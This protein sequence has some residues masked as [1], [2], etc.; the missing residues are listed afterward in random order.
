MPRRACRAGRQHNPPFPGPALSPHQHRQRRA[1]GA[2]T[3]KFPLS[4]VAARELPRQRA[5]PGR[6]VHTPFPAAEPPDRPRRRR[7][8]P[9][10][11]FVLFAEP[12]LGRR[13]AW[14]PYQRLGF[15][16][17]RTQSGSPRSPPGPRRSQGFAL[18][19][20]RRAG[21]SANPADPPRALRRRYRDAAVDRGRPSG[22][23]RG[24][25]PTA[26]LPGYSGYPA[27]PV[28]QQM[29]AADVNDCRLGS[30]PGTTS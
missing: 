21:R 7:R 26:A 20:R 12:Q 11:S 30:G 16:R 2:A 3:R 6:A 27:F 28:G 15:S 8:S 10:R 13:P 23:Q 1:A 9:R 29:A 18:P 25:R 19:R 14:R 17:F 24:P 22:G 4:G 5:P